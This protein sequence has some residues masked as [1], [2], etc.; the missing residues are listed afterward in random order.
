ME[1]AAEVKAAGGG[2]ALSKGELPLA[3]WRR[4]GTHLA[5]L[6]RIAIL[7][8]SGMPDWL[9]YRLADIGGEGAY[10]LLADRS[11]LARENYRPFGGGEREAARLTRAAFRNYSRTVMD[12]L[13]L[14][15]LVER[16]RA[17]THLVETR[18]L[19]REL[20]A[21]RAAI[22][23]TP[24]FGNWDLGAA[25]TATC[26]RPVHAVADQFGP[27]AVD[28][29]VR[30][31]RERVGVRIIPSGPSSAREALRALRH[32]DVLCLAADID[33]SGGGVPVRFLGRMVCL[34]AGPATL[35]LR[36]NVAVIPGYVHR[37]AGGAHEARL[38][39][40]LP[41]PPPGAQD[42]RVRLLTQA[43]ADSFERIIRRDPSQW[44]AFHRL[45]RPV[46]A[47]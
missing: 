35:A 5:V 47:P 36:T 4:R 19:R 1:V 9:R 40:P 26:G 10:R 30:R 42:E 32:G 46:A 23:V 12:F 27:P 38:L 37:L 14:G 31:A 15:R 43:I 25:M 39:D 16:T 45:P 6:L 18:P 44:F 28:R 29:I 21:G 33:R 3:P 17:A 22:V 41:V 24:H 20:A 2:A 34:P 13:I 7:L 11:R 8:T